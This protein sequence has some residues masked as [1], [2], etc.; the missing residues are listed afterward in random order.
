MLR[1]C[2][3]PIPI[4]FLGVLVQSSFANLPTCSSALSVNAGKYISLDGVLI[5]KGDVA[6]SPY[7]STSL[8]GTGA[9]DTARIYRHSSGR[10][11][12]FRLMDHIE[13]LSGACTIAGVP[14]TVSTSIIRD[15]VAAT[16]KANG[17][18]DSFVRVSVFLGEGPVGLLIPTD[19]SKHAL[20]LNWEWGQYHGTKG[21]SEGIKAHVS[22]FQRQHGYEANAKLIG[23]YAMAAIAR[24]EAAR[25]GYGEAILA[26]ASG[27]IAEA[28]GE[29]VFIV[30]DG[31]LVTP[32]PGAILMG[33]TRSTVQWLSERNAIAH[34]EKNFDVS[35][36]L[37]ADEIFL[38]G[39]AA[40]IV[41]VTNVDGTQIGNGTPGPVTRRLQSDYHKLVHG[42]LVGAPAEWFTFID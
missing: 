25:L 9:F 32:P 8:Y 42:E 21:T 19:A 37:S 15:Q 1:L 33:V 27:N 22:R 31:K 3:L 7:S 36:L 10:L 6:F 16:V 38:T 40:E 41:P 39:T 35:A 13:R 24:G 4:L 23:N 29:N 30:K 2:K 28:T 11:A 26:D 20:V 14:L 12:A 34:S 17:F 5:A 18:G